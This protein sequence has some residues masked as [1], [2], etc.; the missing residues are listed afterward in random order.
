[1]KE[2]VS[3][4]KGDI[5]VKGKDIVP[6][7]LVICRKDD[8]SLFRGT[9]TSFTAET[10]HVYG[11]D[12]NE[13]MELPYQNVYYLPPSVLCSFQVNEMVTKRL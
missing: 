11:V 1:M 13:R 6:G 9:I 7:L 10:I 8:E 3:L 5:R 4:S 12:N 2:I